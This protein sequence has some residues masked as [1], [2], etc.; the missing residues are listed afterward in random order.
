MCPCVLKRSKDFGDPDYACYVERHSM[1]GP[2]D[3]EN[4][5]EKPFLLRFSAMRACEVRRLTCLTWLLRPWAS[6]A[7]SH[8]PPTSRPPRL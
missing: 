5:R 2:Q 8:T 4:R 7:S 6:G 3:Y 1:R